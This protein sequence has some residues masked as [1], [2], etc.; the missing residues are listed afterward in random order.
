MG[1]IYAIHKGDHDY[2]YVGQT[3][4]DLQT[5]M[6]AHFGHAKNINK[7]PVHKF[8]NKYKDTIM[9]D[10]IEEGIPI[11]LLN[12]REMR[13]VGVLKGKGYRLLNCT[14]GGSAGTTFS[15]ETR[16]KRSEASKKQKLSPEHYNALRTAQLE[17]AR[18]PEGRKRMSEIKSGEGHH[19]YG[20]PWSDEYRK[21][22][23]E[24]RLATKGYT[25]DMVFDIRA[26]RFMGEPAQTIAD[27][28][29]LSRAT[30]YGIGNRKKWVDVE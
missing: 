17:W 24:K 30:V 28:Y 21:S 15:E 12:E 18:S 27:D 9:V 29:G 14:D 22:Q 26:R 6:V 13:W 10:V 2:R 20:V 11:E 23:A 7:T 4:T 3:R 19:F 5:R 8:I 1:I 16:R 25:R